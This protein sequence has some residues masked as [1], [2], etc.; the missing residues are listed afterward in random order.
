VAKLNGKRIPPKKWEWFIEQV[1]E[2]AG[3][4]ETSGDHAETGDPTNAQLADAVGCPQRLVEMVMKL[5]R[6]DDATVRRN[7]LIQSV[8]ELEF[9]RRR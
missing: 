8:E 2:A 1:F 9:N 5:P 7:V 3:L 4:P 6:T